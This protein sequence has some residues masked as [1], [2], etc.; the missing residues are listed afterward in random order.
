M[1]GINHGVPRSSRGGGAEEK[2]GF[3]AIETPF[4]SI[5]NSDT[6]PTQN[7]S[8]QNRGPSPLAHV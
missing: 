5:T 3:Q 4:L 7:E 2:M 8:N 6:F 1:C